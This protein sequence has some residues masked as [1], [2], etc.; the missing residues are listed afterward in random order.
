MVDCY[1]D[2]QYGSRSVKNLAG[3]LSDSGW[4]A[5]RMGIVAKLRAVG[6]GA[7]VLAALGKAMLSDGVKPKVGFSADVIFQA[8]ERRVTKIIKVMSVDLVIDPAR[9][10]AFLRALNQMEELNRKEAKDAKGR[11]EEEKEY[12]KAI[13]QEQ[14]SWAEWPNELEKGVKDMAEENGIGTQ[15]EKDAQAIR[16]LLDGQTQQD[17]LTAEA[18]KARAVRA[19]MCEYLLA[20]ALAASKLPET[21]KEHVRARFAG[22][23]FEVAELTARSR[24]PAGSL[25][26]CRAAW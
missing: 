6:P 17:A 11:E 2:H 9:G 3:V 15:F 5:G 25:P 16:A 20:S 19:Q 12:V 8:E 24:I 26:T 18:A 22:K 7:G 14:K 1:L 23:V 10:G 13:Q 4:D 21:G